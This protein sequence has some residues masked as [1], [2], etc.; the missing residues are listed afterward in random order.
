MPGALS[1]M[2]DKVFTVVLRP[3]PLRFAKGGLV[4]EADAVRQSGRNGDSVLVHLS[5]VEFLAMQE[6]WGKPTYNPK[7]G[8]PEYWNLKSIMKTLGM[9][10]PAILAVA[11]PGAG[12]AVGE[13]LGASGATASVLGNALLGAGIGGVTNGGK[14]ALIGAGVGGL[15]AAA[16][17]M[18][19][20]A[21]SGTSVGNYL[22]LTPKDTLMGAA[23]G[24]DTVVSPETSMMTLDAGNVVSP[25]VTS[26]PLAGIASPALS[27]EVMAAM[28]P[29]AGKAAE[30]APSF[31]EKYK[32]PLLVGG[33][34]L[35]LSGMGEEEPVRGPQQR[36]SLPASFTEPLPEVTFDRSYV[37]P[38]TA[39]PY[40]TYGRTPF[41]FFD[42]NR[43]P[44]NKAK[45]GALKDDMSE[46]YVTGGVG[47][48]RADTIDA[49]LSNNEYVMDAETVALL[50]NGSPEAGAKKLDELRANLRK[51]KGK[52][53]AKG[54]FS[55][56]AKAPESYMKG[57]A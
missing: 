4:K 8:L 11:A 22:N 14:G 53:L 2:Q 18:L 52:D 7:T 9:I 45:G 31:L 51:H 5:P 44:V 34:A 50:G 41:S 25:E 23:P 16:A 12:S 47:D 6:A 56:N 30:A 19:N 28:A 29:G 54:K 42:N 17:P 32:V 33:G 15:S 57:A 46:S 38:T 3:E 36:G 39:T 20:N 48:G 35:A 24:L 37:G 1:M 10:A 21:L 43:L 26:A 55:S 49:K 40:Y 13:M 27:E